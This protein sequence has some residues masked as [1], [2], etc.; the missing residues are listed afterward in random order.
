MTKP[1]GCSLTELSTALANHGGRSG[2]KCLRPLRDRT[3]I[4]PNARGYETRIGGKVLICPNIDQDRCA[5]RA[6]QACKFLGRDCVDR[7][8]EAPFASM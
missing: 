1:R 7:R 5:V 8:H 2:D 6:D 3:M 4:A